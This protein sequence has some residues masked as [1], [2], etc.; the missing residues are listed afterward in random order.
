LDPDG[1]KNDQ[2]TPKY[3]C[4]EGESA[5]GVTF[6]GTSYS[7]S[8]YGFLFKKGGR[9][10]MVRNLNFRNFKV[11]PIM[12]GDTF[13]ILN[14]DN[15]LIENCNFSNNEQPARVLNAAS[16]VTIRN[17]KFN[18]N[19]R[20]G[21]DV[22]IKNSLIENCEFNGNWKN[23]PTVRSDWGSGGLN[24]IG[25]DV[26]IRNSTMNNNGEN[27]FRQ[28][29]VSENV[30]FTDCQ[31]NSNKHAGILMETAYGPTTFE[32][33]QIRDN[34]AGFKNVGGVLLE[35]AYDVTFK[36]CDIIDNSKQAFKV[37]LKNRPVTTTGCDALCALGAGDM[38]L[39]IGQFFDNKKG[40][41]T[42][43]YVRNIRILGSRIVSK[44]AAN[45]TG[46]G[47]LIGRNPN[48][49]D[50]QAYDDWYI[51]QFIGAGN[52][53]WH[54]GGFTNVF[55]K[56]GGN[57]ENER[58]FVDFATWRTLTGSEGAATIDNV[59][60]SASEWKDPNLVSNPSFDAEAFDTQT[61]SGWLEH[62]YT[63]ASY[64]E[65]NGSGHTGPRHGTHWSGSYYYVYT[66]QT[67]SNLASGLYTLRAKA[68]R[69]GNQ[70]TSYLEAK[71]FGSNA[72]TANIPI[73]TL[74]GAY[75]PV[76]IRDINVTNGSCTIGFWT[77]SNGGNNSWVFFDDVE[78][79]KQQ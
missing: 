40:M 19:L 4:I 8:N 61:P 28:D 34:R 35:T 42:F 17:C 20:S 43:P 23:N 78:F 9:N 41:N 2:V 60:Y 22:A 21:L 79:F 57:F 59:S 55:E 76:E 45:T 27:G 62:S 18:D 77:V 6:D 32:R 51:D 39:P 11:S 72:K 48:D 54:R 69:G 5:G 10:F 12:F 46:Q 52:T 73:G 44:D 26:Q 70:S 71:D 58:Q 38:T 36:N 30:T 31:F 75:S 37:V 16:R 49:G 33:C 67:K 50:Y 63:G 24:F 74:T 53:Y 65:Q 13:E 56:I 66:Y 47:Y 68:K 25:R 3:F 1:F 29:H 15:W 14:Q 64:T 7:T